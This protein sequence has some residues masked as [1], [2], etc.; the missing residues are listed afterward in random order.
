MSISL[1][2]YLGNGPLIYTSEKEG[3]DES[4]DGSFQKPFKTVMRV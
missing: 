1:P 2:V 4:G 3:S